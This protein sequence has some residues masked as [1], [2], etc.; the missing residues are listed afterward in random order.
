MKE[1]K[2]KANEKKEVEKKNDDLLDVV[3]VKIEENNLV[4]FGTCHCSD[5]GELI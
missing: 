5:P 4:F 3:E 2:V 1:L